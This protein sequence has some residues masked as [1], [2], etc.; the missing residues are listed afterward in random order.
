MKIKRILSGLL[1]A[2]ILCSMLTILPT[3]ASAAGLSEFSDIT[4]PATAEAAEIL[5]V[6][7][8]VDGTGNGQF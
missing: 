4:D 1:C 7:N 6:L 8:I 3:P 2:G 5:R